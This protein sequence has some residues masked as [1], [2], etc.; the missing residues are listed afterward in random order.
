MMFLAFSPY[1]R[2]LK[3]NA[4][5]SRSQVLEQLIIYGSGL[6]VPEPFLEQCDFPTAKKFLIRA[7]KSKGKIPS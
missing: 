1:L 6:P 2:T 4:T 3:D 7:I 5:R